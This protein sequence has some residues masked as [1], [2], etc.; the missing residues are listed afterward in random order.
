[1]L[2]AENILV[3]WAAGA[4]G[5][6]ATLEQAA[7]LL[8]VI[9]FFFIPCVKRAV[10]CGPITVVLCHNTKGMDHGTRTIYWYHIGG[11]GSGVI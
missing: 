4:R 3:V 8:F 5:K 7:C 1:M 9:I 6:S 11:G 10:R 2:G